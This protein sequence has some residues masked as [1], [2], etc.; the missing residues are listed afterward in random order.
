MGASGEEREFVYLKEQKTRGG[1]GMPAPQ[2]ASSLLE[3]VAQILRK[4]LEDPPILDPNARC[5][6]FEARNSCK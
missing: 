1:G 2:L 6:V 5:A 3:Y 4:T